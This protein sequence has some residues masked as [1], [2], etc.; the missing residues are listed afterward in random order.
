MNSENIFTVARVIVAGLKGACMAPKQTNPITHYKNY[1][2]TSF[3]AYSAFWLASAATI[4]YCKMTQTRKPQAKPQ[5]DL[6]DYVP[7]DDSTAQPGKQCNRAKAVTALTIGLL[8]TGWEYFRFYETLRDGTADISPESTAN[9]LFY[10][11][12]LLLLT[13]AVENIQLALFAANSHDPSLAENN[14]ALRKTAAF[15]GLYIKPIA[16]PMRMVITR[17]SIA[18]LTLE[19]DSALQFNNFNLGAIIKGMALWGALDLFVRAS[20]NSYQASNTNEAPK[21]LASCSC[22]KRVMITAAAIA[23]NLFYAIND[24]AQY[25]N[26]FGQISWYLGIFL[27]LTA[28]TVVGYH[29]KTALYA[30]STSQSISM[31]CKSKQTT[32]QPLLSQDKN[33]DTASQDTSSVRSSSGE[34]FG[35]PDYLATAV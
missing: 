1:Q 6:D 20:N 2:Q 30:D 19:N 5:Q 9:G 24:S 14:K 33:V 7:F 34:E 31:W 27:P 12:M 15:P 23:C 4:S 13:T 21:Q 16:T 22:S 8:Y 10:T 11:G 17:L 29:Q 35:T 26:F 28:L 18:K 3:W 32:R 25:T